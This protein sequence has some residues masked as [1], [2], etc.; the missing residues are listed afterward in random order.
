L[1]PETILSKHRGYQRM[2]PCGRE[3]PSGNIHNC[4]LGLC[5]WDKD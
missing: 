1:E 5:G 4:F 3:S 2:I